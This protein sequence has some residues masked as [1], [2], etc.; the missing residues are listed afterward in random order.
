MLLDKDSNKLT[1][2]LDFDFAVVANPMEEYLNSFTDLGG[3]VGYLNNE[4]EAATLKGDFSS[5]PADLGEEANK[6]WEL[7]KSWKA[8]A[9]T[10]GVIHPSEIK[11]SD[12]II[13][14]M[15]FQN[16]LCP[17]RLSNASM[18]EKM[19]DTK[20]A[21]LRAETQAKIVAWLDKHGL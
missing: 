12:Q 3:R 5:P 16:L 15:Q 11:G 4:V 19:D 20:K 7:A 1:A 13:D 10:H 18:L 9:K 2:I 8:I 6:D 17:Y 21:E 14:L